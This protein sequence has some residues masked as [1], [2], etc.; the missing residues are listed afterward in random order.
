[1]MVNSLAAA[2]PLRLF[3]FN[4]AQPNLAWHV[5]NDTVMGDRS[6]SQVSLDQGYMHFSGVL[7]TNGGG[8]ASLRSSRQTMD[9]AQVNL[10]RLRI[11]GDGRTYR[12][13]LTSD[14]DR[15]SYQRAFSTIAGEWV[16]VELPVHQFYATWRGRRLNRA[17]LN[18]AAVTGFGLILADGIDGPF[19]LDVSWIEADH[20]D[21]ETKR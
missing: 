10:F 7:N 13:R 20:A 18:P 17:P 19:S 15:A 14:N 12:F 2:E 8:F 4:Q 16:I 9:L 5:V 3:S 6:T 11:R 1:M 21:F